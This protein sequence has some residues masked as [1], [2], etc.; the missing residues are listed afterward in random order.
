MWG[1]WERFPTIFLAGLNGWVF[2]PAMIFPPNLGT[3]IFPMK[4]KNRSGRH[5]PGC[6]AILAVALPIAMIA[7]LASGGEEPGSKSDKPSGDAKQSTW[8]LTVDDKFVGDSVGGKTIKYT[9]AIEATHTGA[10]RFGVYEGTLDLKAEIELPKEAKGFM[11]YEFDPAHV[12]FKLV[13]YDGG[14]YADALASMKAHKPVAGE[15]APV[16]GYKTMVI[17]KKKLV[18]KYSWDVQAKADARTHSKGS[19]E[20]EAEID[21]II[22]AKGTLVDVDLF[23]IEPLKFGGILTVERSAKVSPEPQDPLAPLTPEEKK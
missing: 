18:G 17:Y 1:P 2:C 16:D 23:F 11:R 5:L 20:D 14:Q 19:R 13:P 7:G 10:D 9:L 6:G 22:G 12:R 21:L 3:S 15:L 8:I 4:T